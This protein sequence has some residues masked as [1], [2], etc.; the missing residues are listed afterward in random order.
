LRTPSRRKN[1]RTNRLRAVSD[2]LRARDRAGRSLD[3]T[4]R[5]RCS[6]NACGA[7]IGFVVELPV[8]LDGTKE[9]RRVFYFDLGFF[10]ET[11]NL[12]RSSNDLARHVRHAKKSRYRRGWVPN[13][14]GR[15]RQVNLT[16]AIYPA[17]AICP[18]CRLRLVID[19][20]AL[21]LFALPPTAAA[22]DDNDNS[23]KMFR[24]AAT[25]GGVRLSI[26]GEEARADT[27]FEELRA[28]LPMEVLT[29]K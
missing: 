18:G 6:D 29:R 9:L 21:D 24:A 10:E 5:L 7:T 23:R 16:P 8:T 28:A 1:K 22:D 11:K 25:H 4:E 2:S 14:A 3:I 27:W 26:D 12:Y 17:H 20:D 15:I 19:G 13:I